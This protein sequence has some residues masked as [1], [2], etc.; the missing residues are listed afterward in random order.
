VG[1]IQAYIF[2]MLTMVYMSHKVGHD[3]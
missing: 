1:S 2:T 3:H